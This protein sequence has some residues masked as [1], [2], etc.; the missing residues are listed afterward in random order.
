VRQ[1]PHAATLTSTWP[2]AGSGMGRSTSWRGVPGLLST[3]AFMTKPRRIWGRPQ[4]GQMLGLLNN[5]HVG[6]NFC[7][8]NQMVVIFFEEMNQK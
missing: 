7:N 5:G 4:W 2:A 1:T 8:Q 3:I 6:D